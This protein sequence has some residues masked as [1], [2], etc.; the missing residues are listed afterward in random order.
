MFARAKFEARQAKLP[1]AGSWR[2]HREYLHTLQQRFKWHKP[3]TDLSRG[4][5]V[6]IKND[7]VPLL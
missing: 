2:W 1:L 4:T 5:L 6:L 7:Q 3:Q